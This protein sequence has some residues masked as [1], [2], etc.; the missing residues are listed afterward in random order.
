MRRGIIRVFPKDRLQAR[1][2]PVLLTEAVLLDRSLKVLCLSQCLRSDAVPEQ[3]GAEAQDKRLGPSRSPSAWA[4][5][6]RNPGGPF[7]PFALDVLSSI[8]YYTLCTM[9]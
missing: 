8:M 5:V 7:Q 4:H 9:A 2:C 6:I 1:H 3:P